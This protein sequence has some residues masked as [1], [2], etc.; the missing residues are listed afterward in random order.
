MPIWLRK[1]IFSQINDFYKKEAD[2]MKKATSKSNPNT[3]NFN[4]GETNKSKIPNFVK[5]SPKPKS[6]Y[7]AN[8]SKKPQ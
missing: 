1:F 3:Q 6:N 4:M 5:N 8:I 2:Q 7:T